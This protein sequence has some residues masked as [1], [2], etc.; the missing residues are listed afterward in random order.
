MTG[1]GGTK[2]RTRV[3]QGT[4]RAPPPVG[5]TLFQRRDWE[6]G[7]RQ[8]GHETEAPWQSLVLLLGLS[9]SHIPL[10]LTCRLTVSG[11]RPVASFLGLFSLVQTQ[12]ERRKEARVLIG[13]ILLR[14][15]LLV[16][17]ETGYWLEG[18][19]CHKYG[20]RGGENRNE[21]EAGSW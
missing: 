4:D 6:S 18:H 15:R 9:G 20:R 14:D 19:V 21:G 12:A 17:E 1:G 8:P 5:Q 10:P 16:Q 3:P 7:S 2:S 13:S 11:P